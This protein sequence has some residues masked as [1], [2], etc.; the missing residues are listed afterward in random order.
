MAFSSIP[1]L[2]D[3]MV[4]GDCRGH[5]D[6]NVPGSSTALGHQHDYRLWPKPQASMWPLVATWAT[7]IN[8][9]PGYGRT[10]NPNM[11]LSSGLYFE[12]TRAPGDNSGHSD[13]HGTCGSVALRLQQD[14]EFLKFIL[15]TNHR[16]P[17]SLFPLL[18]PPDPNPPLIPS[19]K[20]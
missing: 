7:D 9:D 10:M 12:F 6:Q 14:P 19:Y 18:Q 13:Q 11:V 8:T 17:S 4:P 20:K 3:T 2:D 5:S 15:H 1:G 16:S